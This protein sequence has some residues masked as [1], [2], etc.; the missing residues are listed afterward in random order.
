MYLAHLNQL[1]FYHNQFWQAEATHIEAS[2]QKL[3]MVLESII[4][5]FPNMLIFFFLEQGNLENLL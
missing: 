1:I 4:E 3:I 2:L 5:G